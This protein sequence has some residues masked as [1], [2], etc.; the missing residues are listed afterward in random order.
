MLNKIQL[1]YSG[2]KLKTKELNMASGNESQRCSI[3]GINEAVIFVKVVTN[4]QIQEKGL[5][6]PCAVH[7]LQ[8]KE[9]IKELNILDDRLTDVIDVMQQ[10]L[11][12][13]VTNLSAIGAMIDS[14][15]DVG[16][17]Q[18]V[19]RNCGY[20]YKRFKESGKLGCP[21]CLLGVCT[22]Y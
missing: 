16:I 7:Y 5:C 13:I 3:C 10:L 11:S 1:F 20:T 8:D 12:G 22:T 17:R 2:C 15:Q 21:N 4:M 19:C 14:G 6:A 18:L 9:K